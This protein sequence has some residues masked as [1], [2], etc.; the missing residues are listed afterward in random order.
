[1]AENISALAWFQDEIDKHAGP[2]LWHNWLFDESITRNMGLHFPKHLIVDTMQLVF[3]L[4]NLPQ[5]LKALAYR[6]LGMQMEDFDDLVTPYSV[7][8]CLDYLRGA[9]GV[10][11]P[12]REEE[13]V[14]DSDGLWKLYKPQSMGTKL[15]RFFSD[16]GRNNAKGIYKA[17][18]NWEDSHARV[19][20]ICGDWPG[21]CITQVPFEKVLYYACRD[22]DALLRLWPLLRSM[23]RQV[24]R[25]L[26]E[27]WGDA[28]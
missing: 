9:M 12:K 10:V 17:W 26:Q 14:R 11:W 6:E 4:G 1:M 5:G 3:H 15:K 8:F 23:K 16:C 24:R 2:I 28:A 25:K 20:S 22:A 21:K 18:D 19:E 13:L 7:P 27:H